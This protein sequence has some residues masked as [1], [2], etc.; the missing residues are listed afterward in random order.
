MPAAAFDVLNEL[1]HSSATINYDPILSVVSS[2]R[3]SVHA[4]MPVCDTVAQCDEKSAIN[5]TVSVTP[6]H[7]PRQL[8]RC[9]SDKLNWQREV[10]IIL[11]KYLKAQSDS[12]STNNFNKILKNLEQSD[13]FRLKT[14]TRIEQSSEYFFSILPLQGAG[15]AIEK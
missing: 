3:C 2:P 5:I 4:E 8:K 13:C 6:K 9:S 10:P 7:N 12:N 11:I 1:P 14:Q 15:R